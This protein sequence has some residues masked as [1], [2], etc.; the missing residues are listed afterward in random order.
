MTK[1]LDYIVVTIPNIDKGS[2][3]EEIL[4]ELKNSYDF[5]ISYGPELNV[6]ERFSIALRALKDGG[7]IFSGE[8]C[9]LR[10]CADRPFIDPRMIECL[11]ESDSPNTLLFN[12]HNLD[13]NGF[14]FGAELL[15]RLISEELFFGAKNRCVDEEHVTLSL[16]T[17]DR[18]NK[19]YKI[20]N[21]LMEYLFN[22]RKIK[23]DADTAEEIAFLNKM[24]SKC[25]IIPS[26]TDLIER[27]CEAH[28]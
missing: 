1:G 26:S 14:G 22:M 20:P 24:V 16:Y 9:V 17:D 19:V 5:I 21:N 3:L 23:C 7:K 2:K 8:Y 27:L 11:L 25:K 28:D 15:G 18:F 6:H 4:F 10:V 13:G 12:H